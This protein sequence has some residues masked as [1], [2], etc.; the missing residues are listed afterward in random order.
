MCY[1]WEELQGH[2]GC[3]GSFSKLFFIDPLI[4]ATYLSVMK[5]FHQLYMYLIFFCVIHYCVTE[6][7]KCYLN[8]M[9]NDISL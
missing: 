8:F 4:P 1:W 7:M 5:P 3:L 2:V 9:T 6:A